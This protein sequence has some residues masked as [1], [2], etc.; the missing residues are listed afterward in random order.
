MDKKKIMAICGVIFVIVF[1][2]VCIVI[3]HFSKQNLETTQ[4]EYDQTVEKYGQVE[5]ETVN[6]LVA[7]FNTEIMDSGLN[8]PA[9]DDYM[10]VEDNTYWYA[11]TDDISYYLKPV[12]FSGKK[13]N[14]ILDMSALYLEKDGYNEETSTEYVKK[15]IK[16]NNSDLTENEIDTLIKEAKKLSAK[17]E[18]SNN[19]KGI[20]VG[21][22]EAN[23]HYE[24][25]VIRLNK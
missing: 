11:L 3:V 12:E 25:Q 22:V 18:M 24:Y 23:D 14:D 5:K 17:K 13:E 1:I 4:K 16:A 21:F 2:A 9:S 15:L 6:I 7:K 19:G 8:T 20:S 10:V